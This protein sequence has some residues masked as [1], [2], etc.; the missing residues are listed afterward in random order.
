MQYVAIEDWKTKLVGFSCDGMSANIAEGGMKGFLKKE[1]PWIAMFWCL[2]HR[3]E[4]SIKDALNPTF[5]SMIN[6][7]L[8]RMYYVYHKSPK[9]C[10]DLEHIIVELKS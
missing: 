2:A 7:V 5:F 8:M 3:L 1:V 9:K 10:R 4:L 6:D